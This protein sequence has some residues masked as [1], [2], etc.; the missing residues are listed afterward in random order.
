MSQKLIP[1]IV[2]AAALLIGS[3]AIASAQNSTNRPFA[4]DYTQNLAPRGAYTSNPYAGTVWDGV[5]P[6]G[7]DQVA[8]PYAGTVWDGVVPY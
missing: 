4:P 7:S 2:A 5:V 8:N 1:A 3:T 6:Y